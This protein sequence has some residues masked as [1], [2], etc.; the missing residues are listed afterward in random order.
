MV[1]PSGF[2]K[3]KKYGNFIINSGIFIYIALSISFI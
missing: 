3:H 2:F 1:T